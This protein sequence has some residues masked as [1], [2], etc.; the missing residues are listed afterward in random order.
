VRRKTRNKDKKKVRRAKTKTPTFEWRGCL[1][2]QN[3]L[4]TLYLHSL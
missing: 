4:I 1:G 3:A 2:Y